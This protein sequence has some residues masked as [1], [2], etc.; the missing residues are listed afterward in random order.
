M[1]KKIMKTA[2]TDRLFIVCSI[3]LMKNVDQADLDCRNT[4][5]VEDLYHKNWFYDYNGS[6][7][8]IPPA[9]YIQN[10]R[11]LFINGRHRAILLAR[12]IK[13]FPFLIGNLDLVNFGSRENDNSIRVLNNIKVKDMEEHSTFDFPELE[14]GDFDPA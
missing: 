4:K 6:E 12:H 7:Y 3:K 14:F 11:I 10:G 2:D 13:S 8:F 1:N 9:A 5:N